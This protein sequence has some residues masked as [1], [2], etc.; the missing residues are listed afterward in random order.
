M[1][2]LFANLPDVV[3]YLLIANIAAFILTVFQPV[4]A[5]YGALYS[6]RSPNFRPFQFVT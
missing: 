6:F 5:D 1:R 2:N 3:K 4:I